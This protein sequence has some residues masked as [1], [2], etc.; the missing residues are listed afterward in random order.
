MTTTKKIE[1]TTTIRTQETILTLTK[2]MKNVITD[3][4]V[5]DLVARAPK[6][7]II[8]KMTTITEIIGTTAQRDTETIDQTDQDTTTSLT[9]NNQIQKALI[10]T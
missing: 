2:D 7:D 4:K 10:D 1:I 8:V 9:R 6:V 3:I 5:Q